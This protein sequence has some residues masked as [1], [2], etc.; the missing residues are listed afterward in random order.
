[1]FKYIWIII[2]A[3]LYLFVWGLVIWDIIIAKKEYKFV[4]DFTKGWFLLHVLILFVASLIAFIDSRI[5]N[6]IIFMQKI[7]KYYV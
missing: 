5:P 7:G 1:M 3:I 2:L 4:T 6:S